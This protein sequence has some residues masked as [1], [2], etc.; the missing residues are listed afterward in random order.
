M[1]EIKHRVWDGERFHYNDKLEYLKFYLLSGKAFVPTEFDGLQEKDWPVTQFTGLK[2]KN[3]VDIYEGEI[4][5]D[6]FGQVNEI[7]YGSGGFWFNWLDL[8]NYTEQICEGEVIG[9][10]H[11]NPEL[12][13]K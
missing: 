5:K 9:N 1:R 10:I 13:E 6:H 3:G 7:T 8:P 12:L 11:E 4:V 2:D